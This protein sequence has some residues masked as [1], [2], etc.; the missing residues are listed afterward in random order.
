MSAYDWKNNNQ[1]ITLENAQV[2]PVASYQPSSEHTEVDNTAVKRVVRKIDIRIVPYVSLLYLCSYLDRV[3]IGNAK[4]AGLT[5]DLNMNNSMYSVALSIFFVGYILF[6]VPANVLLKLFGPRRWIAIIMLTWGAIMASMAAVKTSAGL[7]V[8]RFF[9]GVAEAGLFPGI[10][11]YLS[12]WYPRHLQ[13]LR[14]SIFYSA[15]T[16]AGAFGGVL[17]FGIVQMDGVYGLRGWQWIFLIEAIPTLLFTIVT[18]VIL[19]EYPETA[20]FLTE[21]ERIIVIRQIE[22]H[23]GCSKEKVFAKSQLLAAFTDIRVYFYGLIILLACTCSY[24]LSL[25]LPSIILGIGYT[26]TIA[27]VMSAPPY[28]FACV[29]TV[30]MAYF[31]DRHKQRAIYLMCAS[32]VG[33]LGFALLIALRNK[34]STAM[35]IAATIATCG[36]FACIPLCTVWNAN[37]HGEHTKRAVAIAMVAGMANVGGI[38]SGQVYRGED[39]PLY[40]RGHT[41]CCVLMGAAA[42]LTLITRIHLQRENLRRDQLAP[43]VCDDDVAC[44]GGHMYDKVKRVGKL[45]NDMQALNSIMTVPQIWSHA[46]IGSIL[47]LIFVMRTFFNVGTACFS[48]YLYPSF[49]S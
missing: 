36:C 19:P 11:Y 39:A 44:E 18:Y 48:D 6:E 28:V 29:F 24:S 26:D 9:L 12:L 46:L 25:F 2:Q 15:S 41:I 21:E 35:Y 37:N 34:G 31:S 7:I 30:A 17:A 27:Q 10:I 4:L 22:E 20:K 38:I 40:T 13:T 5:E 42:V 16:V 33:S 47:P 8:A 23:S 14:V 32:L 1:P 49:Y 45:Q 43:G 3:N